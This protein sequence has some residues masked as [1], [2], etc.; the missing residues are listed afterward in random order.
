MSQD[1]ALKQLVSRLVKYGIGLV[2]DVPATVG[3]T[4]KCVEQVSFIQETLFGR[5]WSFTSDLA[6]MDTAYTNLLVE[7]HTDTIYLTSLTLYSP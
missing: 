4:R 1:E 2:K 5:M 6:I 7:S 3:D